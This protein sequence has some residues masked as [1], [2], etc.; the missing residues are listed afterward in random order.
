[1]MLTRYKQLPPPCYVAR[2][3]APLSGGELRCLEGQWE[4]Y[5]LVLVLHPPCWSSVCLKPC[6]FVEVALYWDA[7]G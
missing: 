5:M 6:F 2:L 1:M 3:R 7:L 4:P